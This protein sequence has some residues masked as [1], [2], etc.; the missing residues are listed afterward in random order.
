MH[1]S[2][3]RASWWRPLLTGMVL[4]SILATAVA[5]RAQTVVP[6]TLEA[7]C[8]SECSAKG[9]EAEFCTRVCRVPPAPQGR[10]DEVTDWACMATCGQR[11]GKYRECKPSCRVR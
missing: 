9:Y 11:G 2:S 7:S 3:Q 1:L 8:A 4:A 5:S 10:A 6:D